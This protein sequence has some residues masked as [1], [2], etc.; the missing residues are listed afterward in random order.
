MA[1]TTAAENKV[2]F[3]LKNCCYAVITETAGAISYGTPVAIPGAVQAAYQVEEAKKDDAGTY[4]VIAYNKTGSV[5]SASAT[6]RVILP[7][8]LILLR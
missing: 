6:V 2:R 8:T 1:E 7:A 4:T 3:N 5:Q